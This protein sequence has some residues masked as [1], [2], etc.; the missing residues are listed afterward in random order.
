MC[1]L[2]E[3]PARDLGLQ[4]LWADKA[5]GNFIGKHRIPFIAFSNFDIVIRQAWAFFIFQS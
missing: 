4:Y 3:V 5:V 2:G 1:A